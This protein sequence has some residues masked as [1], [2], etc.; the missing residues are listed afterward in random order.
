[1]VLCHCVVFHNVGLSIPVVK[2][3]DSNAEGYCLK[4]LN[5]HVTHC[6]LQK[7]T[8]TNRMYNGHV[9]FS[10]CWNTCRLHNKIVGYL[11]ALNL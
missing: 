7:Y 5:L 10:R 4:L 1:M 9:T 8:F 6:D 3:K 11:A 2:N